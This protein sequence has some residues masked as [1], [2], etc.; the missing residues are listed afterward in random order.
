LHIHSLITQLTI[1]KLWFMLILTN[2]FAFVRMIDLQF[3]NISLQEIVLLNNT[4]NISLNI[5]RL[6]NIHPIISGN[7]WFKLQYYLKE[8]IAGKF[9]TIAT[10]GGAYSNHIVATAEACTKNNLEC[11]GIIRGDEHRTSHTLELAKAYGMQLLFVNRSDFK[12]K[13]AI[14]EKYKHHNWYWIN[15]GGYGL[16]GAEGAADIMQFVP[17]DT[18]HIIIATGTGTTFAGL[19]KNLLPHQKVMGINVLKGNISINNEI[20]SLLTE[21]EQHK[22]FEI[23]ND[24]HFGGYA[25]HPKELIE[26][27][28]QLWLQYNLP[29]DIV[30]TSKMMFA[31][32][33]LI[34][35]NYFPTNSKIVAVHS[36]GLQGNF[37]LPVN[38]LP[39]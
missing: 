32:F 19:L 3:N 25:K 22:N 13:D 31:I 15:E 26:F 27:M 24:Y 9:L 20:N 38:T 14:K 36:G 39:F 23:I 30:Y 28:K 33:D 18:T 37:S 1:A 16:K 2:I 11:F 29:T 5:L 21:E 8:A 6:D 35:K 10:F 17:V 7:K 4:E 34:N 12:N